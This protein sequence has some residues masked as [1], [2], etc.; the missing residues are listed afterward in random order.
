MANQKRGARR[1]ETKK[2]ENQT[3]TLTSSKPPS[4]T[5]STKAS[6]HRAAPNR[7]GREGE[8]AFPPS[9]GEEEDSELTALRAR[10][11]RALAELQQVLA[12]VRLQR[13]ARCRLARNRY[14]KMLRSLRAQRVQQEIEKQNRMENLM[15]RTQQHERA[16]ETLQDAARSWLIARSAQRDVQQE[17][18]PEWLVRAGQELEQM[19]HQWQQRQEERLEEQELKPRLIDP[20]GS[21]PNAGRHC[22]RATD[23]TMSPVQF[24][25]HGKALHTRAGGEAE[26]TKQSGGRQRK[27]KIAQ[28][29][30]ARGA[31]THGP[32][33][34][35]LQATLAESEVYA[36]SV[37]AEQDRMERQVRAEVE[38]ARQLAAAIQASMDQ[39]IVGSQSTGATGVDDDIEE[40]FR[41]LCDAAGVAPGDVYRP[42]SQPPRAVEDVV[43]QRNCRRVGV[44][45]AC[46]GQ[47]E[48][49]RRLHVAR[50]RSE[51]FMRNKLGKDWRRAAERNLEVSRVR[52]AAQRRLE[53]EAQ[54][55]L[56]GGRRVGGAGS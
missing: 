43:F 52:Y 44:T 56:G 11:V 36:Q 47:R 30:A 9:T 45:V 55:G 28:N 15:M 13:A 2:N 33:D 18:E 46:G 16:V 8:E 37:Q 41:E 10:S 23:S 53:A 5:T 6:E 29:A 38:E 50:A 35:G 12:A 21:P 49:L 48:R 39:G 20:G 31:A 54:M 40:Q 25:G 19:L 1:D 22:R 17:E 51:L 14:D 4:S 34:A 42:A 27:L 24:R 32:Q 26:F 7:K 3:T